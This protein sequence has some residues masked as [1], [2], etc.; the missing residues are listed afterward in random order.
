M[1]D[2]PR[3]FHRY[4]TIVCLLYKLFS[5]HRIE[6]LKK[7]VLVKTY[8]SAISALTKIIYQLR[9][10]VMIVTAVCILFLLKS[11]S[12]NFQVRLRLPFISARLNFK[13][14]V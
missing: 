14:H 12:L 5:E 3:T 7:V 1:L 9:C 2:Q 13:I 10:S 8:S 6:R 11:F 4:F